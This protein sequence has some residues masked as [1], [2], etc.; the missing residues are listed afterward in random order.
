MS[1]IR[2]MELAAV[3]YLCVSDSIVLNEI[4]TG[5]KHNT[6]TINERKR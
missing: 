2:W 4:I 1:Y 6:L 3:K 5:G